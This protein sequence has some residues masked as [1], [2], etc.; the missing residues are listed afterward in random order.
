MA[1]GVFATGKG[2]Q[3]SAAEVL[4]ADQNGDQGQFHMQPAHAQPGRVEVQQPG[5]ED[6]GGQHRRLHDAAVKLALHHAEAFVAD[7]IVAH[8]VV[9]EQAGQVEQPGKPADHGDDV[10]G[11]QPEVKHGVTPRDKVCR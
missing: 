3:L 1:T 6:Q 2:A 5:A 10:Q 4:I 11:F 8:G 7:R 9:D